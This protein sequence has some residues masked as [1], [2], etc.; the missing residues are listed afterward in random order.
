MVGVRL[1][2]VSRQ[3]AQHTSTTTLC[4]VFWQCGF[5][6]M[7]LLIKQLCENVSLTLKWLLMTERLSVNTCVPTIMNEWS[8]VI[9]Y[10]FICM[11]ACVVDELSTR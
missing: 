5:W 10:M 9:V 4:Y 2:G 3:V 7:K 11:R 6:L 8:A 1:G